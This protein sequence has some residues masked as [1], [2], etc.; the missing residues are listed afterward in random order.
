MV[1][2]EPRGAAGFG[3]ALVPARAVLTGWSVDEGTVRLTGMLRSRPDAPG[4]RAPDEACLTVT[5]REGLVLSCPAL[6]EPVEGG[7]AFAG[8][9]P[10]VDLADGPE[11]LAATAMQTVYSVRL[12]TRT[13][14]GVEARTETL[15]LVVDTGTPDVGA[16]V[17]H[18]RIRATRNA[19]GN[20]E[21]VESRTAPQ[22]VDVRWTA[23]SILRF[24]GVWHGRAQLPAEVLCQHFEHPAD[25]IGLALSLTAEGAAY[26]FEVDIT[27]L[28]GL[29][30]AHGDAYEGRDPDPW[31]LL[32]PFHDHVATQ[33]FDRTRVSGFAEPRMIGGR[34][35]QLV[36][37]R[38]DVVRI[39]IGG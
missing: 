38:D 8:S 25:A 2:P 13:G 39:G 5:G 20:L 37:A 35:V 23:P 4:W 17:G 36:L 19:V 7:V 16:V 15:A 21:L 1:R 28:L 29:V 6:L 33:V 32:L 10:A 12:E 34:R 9:I 26:S 30:D 22:L 31:H 3:L 27:V 11:H 14:I 24:E 18:R